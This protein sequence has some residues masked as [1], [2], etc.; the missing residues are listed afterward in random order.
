MAKANHY[1]FDDMKIPVTVSAGV[2]WY[3]PGDIPVYELEGDSFAM[4]DLDE[5]LATVTA[6]A[7]ALT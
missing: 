1:F 7:S 6:P 3:A 5:L 4:R 2:T